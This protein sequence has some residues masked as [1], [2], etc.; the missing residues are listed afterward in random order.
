LLAAGR[1]NGQSDW[2]RAGEDVLLRA[3]RRPFD[4]WGIDDITLCHGA[5]GVAHLFHGAFRHTARQEFQAAA[6]HW[7][8]ATVTQLR[9]HTERSPHGFDPSGGLLLGTPGAVLAIG[10]ALHRAHSTW[11]TV[12]GVANAGDDRSFPQAA[13]E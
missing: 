1:A 5:A 9:A 7:F 3:A 13:G 4:R 8:G 10:S 12:L 2:E 6:R 11:D